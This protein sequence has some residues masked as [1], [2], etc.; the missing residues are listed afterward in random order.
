MFAQ[1]EST[2]VTN[3]KTAR[4]HLCL[5]AIRILVT[6]TMA[7]VG[8]IILYGAYVYITS[9]TGSTPPAIPRGPLD[10]FNDEGQSLARFLRNGLMWIRHILFVAGILNMSA[11]LLSWRCE[12]KEFHGQ[13]KFFNF[14]GFLLV[15]VLIIDIITCSRCDQF[16]SFD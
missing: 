11:L 16:I 5:N 9:A 10:I 8:F 2:T 3:Q 12:C 13:K 15:T 6:I 1:I 4:L 14:G 7:A